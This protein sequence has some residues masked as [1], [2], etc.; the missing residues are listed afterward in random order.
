MSYCNVTNGLVLETT[1]TAGL[2]ASQQVEQSKNVA[3]P[4][5][6]ASSVICIRLAGRLINPQERLHHIH[7]HLQAYQM[8]M[9]HLE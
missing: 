6:A 4:L 7:P 8:A 3:G 1:F 9:S 2:M 5:S